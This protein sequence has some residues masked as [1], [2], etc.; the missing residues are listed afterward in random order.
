MTPKTAE[1]KRTHRPVDDRVAELEQKIAA[2]KARAA[3]K[4]AKA[5]PE[6]KALLV[7]VKALDK[8]IVVAAEVR[9]DGLVRAL[10]ASRAPLSEQVVALGIRLPDAKAKRERRRKGEAA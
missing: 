9:N 2:I 7:A 8:A 4:Q 10:E 5:Q 6:G 3:A 1:P